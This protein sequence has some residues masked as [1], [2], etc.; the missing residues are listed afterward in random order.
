VTKT[1]RTNSVTKTTRT[2]SQPQKQLE[3]IH[4]DKNN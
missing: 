3:Q 1:T 2:N 4:S